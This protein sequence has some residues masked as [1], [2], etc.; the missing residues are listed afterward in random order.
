[1][2]KPESKHWKET[3]LGMLCVSLGAGLVRGVIGFPLEQPFESIKTQWQADPKHPNEWQIFKE[4][5][6]QKGFY[7]GFFAGSL[8]NLG[9]ILIKQVYRYPL[10]IGLPPFFEEKL[11]TTNLEVVKAVSGLTIALI[12]SFILCPFE[13][14][15]VFIMTL[16]HHQVKGNIGSQWRTHFMH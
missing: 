12:E 13:R 6:K 5:V 16:T 1:M 10:M 14:L 7:R 9:R 3:K 11:H 4:I 2:S 15:K 8:P